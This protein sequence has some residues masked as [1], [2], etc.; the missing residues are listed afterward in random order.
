MSRRQL[1]ALLLALAVLGGLFAIYFYVWP[2]STDEEPVAHP[3]VA[4]TEVRLG[5]ILALSGDYQSLGE[6]VRDGQKVAVEELNARPQAK[7]KYRLVLEDSKADKEIAAQK[8]KDLK[9][10]GVDFVA[11]LLGSESALHALPALAERKMLLVSGVNTGA[12]LSLHGGKHFFRIIPSDE[13]AVQNLVRWAVELKLQRAA[14]VYLDDA[15][16]SGLKDAFARTYPASGGTVA[17]E[18]KTASKQQAFREVALALRKARPDL[19]LLFLRPLEAGLLL[20]ACAELGLKARFMGTDTLTGSEV[21][22]T[23]GV[24]VAG[25]M[26]VVPRSRPSPT[27]GH[28]GKLFATYRQRMGF[29]PTADPPLYAVLGYDA[30]HVLAKAIEAAGPEV[31]PAIRALEGLQHTGASGPIAFSKNH[32]LLVT[33]PYARYEYLQRPEGVRAREVGAPQRP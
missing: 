26:Y 30:V 7:Y 31:E 25:V 29:A 28:F 22:V 9:A 1:I 15:W 24:A 4:A 17:L 16:G 2:T 13:V 23:G 14:V 3:Q 18:V 20:T 8:V 27:A 21:H 33:T 32:D 19:V 12:Q 6:L 10:A 11:E 5:S